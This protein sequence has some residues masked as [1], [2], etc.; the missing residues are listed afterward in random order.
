MGDLVVLF[1][2]QICF[3]QR[4]SYCFIMIRW[5][6]ECA[7]GPWR[8]LKYLTNTSADQYEKLVKNSSAEYGPA[9]R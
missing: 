6:L 3:C 2:D 7:S 9:G 5:R 4:V 1:C 8:A